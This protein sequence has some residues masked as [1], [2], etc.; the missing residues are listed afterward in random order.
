MSKRTFDDL[1]L[2]QRRL[3]Q[4][5]IGEQNVHHRLSGLRG[6]LADLLDQVDRLT[7]FPSLHAGRSRGLSNLVSINK[8]RR[9]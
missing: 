1:R 6:D 2:R 3:H 7:A 5:A 8:Y 9:P 4:L